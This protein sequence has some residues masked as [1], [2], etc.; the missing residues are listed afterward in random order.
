[1]AKEVDFDSMGGMEGVQGY[2]G[3]V[4][5]VVLEFFLGGIAAGGGETGVHVCS[6]RDAWPVICPWE[7]AGILTVG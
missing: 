5:C 4:V 3:A 1:V 6:G 2:V 7:S